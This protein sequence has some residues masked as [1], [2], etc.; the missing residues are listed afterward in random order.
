MDFKTKNSLGMWVNT[1]AF[2]IRIF[3][4][5]FHIFLT[6]LLK[7][8]V[9]FATKEEAAKALD[10]LNHTKIGDSDFE[11]FVRE[12]REDRNR[13]DRGERRERGERR[14]GGRSGSRGRRNEDVFDKPKRERSF[15]SGSSK[16]GRQIF[17]S[18]V[19]KKKQLIFLKMVINRSFLKKKASILNQLA[20]PQ[21]PLQGMWT[22][23]ESRHLEE[24]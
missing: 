13:E 20:G 21:G 19:S 1:S 18:N 17:I 6:F 16:Q 12:D 8:I 5:F 10:T 15:R 4:I 11:I 23:R 14:R 3:F 7:S 24:L 22:D 9:E 2:F